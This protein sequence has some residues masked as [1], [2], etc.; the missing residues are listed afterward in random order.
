M[1]A[2]LIGLQS[3]QLHK[4]LSSSTPV[5]SLR[6]FHVF[7]KAY[8]HCR[9]KRTKLLLTILKNV[10]GIIT[11][12]IEE[13]SSFYFYIA[14]YCGHLIDSVKTVHNL[15]TSVVTQ[16]CI[17]ILTFIHQACI[18]VLFN[19][20]SKSFNLIFSIEIRL[21]LCHGILKHAV[22][23]GGGNM[24]CTSDGA[25]SSPVVAADGQLSMCSLLFLVC[26]CPG[27]REQIAGASETGWDSL[28]S[29]RD[30]RWGRTRGGGG[31][32]RYIL[33]M[34]CL[35]WILYTFQLSPKI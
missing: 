10:E 14:S 3:T 19:I 21:Q 2:P 25:L 9:N 5:T 4:H 13:Y 23:A 17:C 20:K 11:S 15:Y 30:A 28:A 33:K 32:G 6:M 12:L 16:I 8:I 29:S 35:V 22:I 7:L 27:L 26:W 18:F 34:R 24:K 31:R 1:M